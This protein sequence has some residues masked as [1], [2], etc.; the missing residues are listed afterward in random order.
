MQTRDTIVAALWLCACAPGSVDLGGSR[1]GGTDWIPIPTG[2][3]ADASAP[4]PIPGPADASAPIPIPGPSPTDAGGPEASIPTRDAGAPLPPPSDAGA[5]LPSSP[6][7]GGPVPPVMDAGAPG[8]SLCARA[9]QRVYRECSLGFRS[10]FWLLASV[11]Q[12]IVL[13]RATFDGL[14]FGPRYLLPCFRGGLFQVG[15]LRIV[16]RVLLVPGRRADINVHDRAQPDIVAA[17]RQLGH[18]RARRVLY[19]ST[20][21]H[22]DIRHVPRELDPIRSQPRCYACV[23][24]AVPV[25]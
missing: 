11:Y 20:R 25:V 13:R 8:P 12:V 15:L 14:R 22:L 7:A 4:I 1:E 23:S 18:H 19:S 24:R 21:Y 16:L 9:C 5:P 2:P 6:D 3:G 10:V 17:G